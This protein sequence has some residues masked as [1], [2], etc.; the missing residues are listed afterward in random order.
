MTTIHC[1]TPWNCF[2][3]SGVC[4]EEVHDTKKYQGTLNET[5]SVVSEAIQSLCE[6]NL[7]KLLTVCILLLFIFMPL[8][9]PS[10]NWMFSQY[11]ILYVIRIISS[12][13]LSA[14][15]FYITLNARE[16]YHAYINLQQMIEFQLMRI[17]SSKRL[18]K[19][20]YMWRHLMWK[21]W[22]I[23]YIYSVFT[24][25]KCLQWN[26]H[27][28]AVIIVEPAV[29]QFPCK[30]AWKWGIWDFK[31]IVQGNIPPNT[32]FYEDHVQM[33]SGAYPRHTCITKAYA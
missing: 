18:I 22:L 12:M 3:L 2:F 6:G 29:R 1:K 19:N 33:F 14:Y 15:L 4:S 17:R 24:C 32:Y 11:G 31:Q 13:I 26:M 10:G 23:Q 21:I 5:Q 20:S 8:F 16:E 30:T 25:I 27:W 9:F 28:M 7:K